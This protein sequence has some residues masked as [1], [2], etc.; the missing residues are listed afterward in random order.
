[1]K[2]YTLDEIKRNYSLVIFIENEEQWNKIYEIIDGR[3]ITT[4]YKGA[5]CYKLSNGTYSSS[6][7]KYDSGAYNATTI[8]QFN[9]IID[10]MET[11]EERELL[12][13]NL[14]EE[15]KKFKSTVLSICNLE[16]LDGRHEG[17]DIYADGTKI[18]VLKEAG[19][20]DLWFEPVYKPIVPDITIN[21]YKGEFFDNYV[22]F[23]CA[24]IDRSL[25]YVLNDD[26]KRIIPE[27]GYKSITSVT[28]G[29]GT[30]TANEIEEIAEYYNKNILSKP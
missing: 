15:F 4:D 9:Q 11:K 25:F 5:H 3:Y 29:K 2:T 8:I 21:G 7:T 16:N 23:G 28:I 10:F 24:K 18:E 30:F 14:K 22:K 26:I 6:S 19:V 1:M 27:E 13:Y 20:L 17:I 12:G